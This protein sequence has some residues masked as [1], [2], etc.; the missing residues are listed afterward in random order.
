[1][2]HLVFCALDLE[3]Y[4]GIQAYH[5]VSSADG[6]PER[7][8]KLDQ[9]L[10]RKSL[11]SLMKA[12]NDWLEMMLVRPSGGMK[13]RSTMLKECFL[14]LEIILGY[15]KTACIHTIHCDLTCRGAS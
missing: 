1:M 7:D 10:S 8:G 2:G 15:V 3:E 11:S 5:E 4:S 9:A 6:E 13:T 12:N 14:A